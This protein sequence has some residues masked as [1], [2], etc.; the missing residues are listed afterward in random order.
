MALRETSMTA[1]GWLWVGTARWEKTD[2][3]KPGD[4]GAPT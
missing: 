2:T 1:E 4:E 3:V